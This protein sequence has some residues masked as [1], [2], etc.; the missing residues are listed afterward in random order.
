MK[1]SAM[2]RRQS[3]AETAVKLR[4]SGVAESVSKAFDLAALVEG[5]VAP[6]VQT[7]QDASAPEREKAKRAAESGSVSTAQRRASAKPA[8]ARDQS[9][10]AWKPIADKLAAKG[11]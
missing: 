1:A 2:W 4:Q 3:I 8:T 7:T 9:Y 5:A 11:F 10:A 6:P